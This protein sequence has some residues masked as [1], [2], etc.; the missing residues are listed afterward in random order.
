VSGS[1]RVLRLR[2]SVVSCCC[3]ENAAERSHE[4]S[5][6]FRGGGQVNCDPRA[7]F[8]P[9]GESGHEHADAAVGAAS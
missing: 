2:N 8:F 6:V 7:V 5:E 9:S 1:C 3:A 4:L